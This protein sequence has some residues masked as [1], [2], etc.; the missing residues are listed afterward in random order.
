MIRKPK[1]HP[2]YGTN[3]IGINFRER[4]NIVMF[5]TKDELETYIDNFNHIKHVKRETWGMDWWTKKEAMVNESTQNI[6][7]RKLWRKRHSES[8][9]KDI[10]YRVDRKIQRWNLKLAPKTGEGIASSYHFDFIFYGEFYHAPSSS[11]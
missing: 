9:Q 2:T 3:L 5:A 10:L 1:T 8:F 4:W 7:F 6:Y 11:S